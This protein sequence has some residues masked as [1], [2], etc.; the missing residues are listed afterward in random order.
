MTAL[1]EPD[2]EPPLRDGDFE[3][4]ALADLSFAEVKDQ[5]AQLGSAARLSHIASYQRQ[6]SAMKTAEVAAIAAARGERAAK[7][8]LKDGKTS[9]GAIAKAA[10]RAEAAAKNSELIDK[11]AAGDLSE[12]QLD[13]I[14]DT[15]AKTD[16]EAAVDVAF[17]DDVAAADPDQGQSIA[18]D[19][20]ADRATKDGVQSEHERQRAL[21]RASKYH[22]K[23]SGLDTISIEGDGVAIKNMWDKIKAR[24]NQLYR[25]DG[26]RDLTSGKHP[27]TFEQRLFDATYELLCGVTTTPTGTKFLSLIHI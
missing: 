21:R 11:L 18:K 4:G 5:L 2:V 7:R 8:A 10:K 24:A 25:S 27:R 16:G 13:V 3:H 9:K 20:I 1:F 15:A 22:S 26:D 14:A 17:I 12:E 19:F 6:L 23:K